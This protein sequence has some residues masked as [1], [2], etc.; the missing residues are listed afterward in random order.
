V[1]GSIL[2]L[3]TLL[4]SFRVA[5]QVLVAFFGVACLPA[6]E[7]WYSGLIPYPILLVIQIV[8]LLIMA[9]ISS[10]V[11]RDSGF[12]ATLRPSWSHYLVGFSTVYAAAMALRY[13]LTMIFRPE[14]R[15]YG[16][17]IPIVFHFVLAG[18]IFVLGRFHAKLW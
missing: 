8:M 13:V 5:G 9:K 6:M 11:C 14:L 4:F 3:L 15:W 7:H 10:D 18:F 12:F 1:H 2:V 16:G 17:T